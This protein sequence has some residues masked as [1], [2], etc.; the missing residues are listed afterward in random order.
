[1]AKDQKPANGSD[2]AHPR[3]LFSD[4]SSRTSE[5]AKGRHDIVESEHTSFFWPDVD[6]LLTQQLAGDLLDQFEGR[7]GPILEPLPRSAASG[8][9]IDSSDPIDPGE[10][11]SVTFGAITGPVQPVPE[12]KLSSEVASWSGPPAGRR[13]AH[14]VDPAGFDVAEN[15]DPGAGYDAFVPDLMSGPFAPSQAQ[16]LFTGPWSEPGRPL[17][18]LRPDPVVVNLET[19]PSPA[20]EEP[21]VTL[22]GLRGSRLFDPRPE[23]EPGVG[24]LNVGRLFDD[25][26]PDRS[27]SA[28]RANRSGRSEP[29]DIAVSSARLVSPFDGPESPERPLFERE[30]VLEVETTIPSLPGGSPLDFT[31]ELRLS[32]PAPN[33]GPPA[34]PV[35]LARSTV[36]DPSHGAPAG[37][38]FLDQPWTAP[39][40]TGPIAAS[41]LLRL[42]PARSGGLLY[43]EEDP[44][45]PSSGPHAVLRPMEP[46]QPNNGVPG[47]A[48]LLDLFDHQ[49]FVLMAGAA[50][51]LVGG[52]GW[53]ALS[54]LGAGGSDLVLDAS[55]AADVTLVSAGSVAGPTTVGPGSASPSAAV[56]SIAS[57]STTTASR[58]TTTR[59]GSTTSST[60]TG[61]TS[62]SVSTSGPSTSGPTTSATVASTTSTEVTTTTTAP[63]TT[64][65]RPTTTTTRPTTTTARPTTT[66][67]QPTTTTTEAP[68]TTTTAPTTPTS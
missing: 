61:S 33:P 20:S 51:L 2:V 32:S 56:S 1:M 53:F 44:A 25:A 13:G 64:T 29:D 14:D 45:Y 55:G 28:Q 27:T 62:S 10:F 34:A 50:A 18:N 39:E 38:L 65:T 24:R 19:E 40:A 66:T 23:V 16:N 59:K 9:P 37:S 48:A 46:L 43:L 36:V 60:V 6:E 54:R 3:D 4:R 17:D 31:S 63:T 12:L 15:S 57:G 42:E 41:S 21:M 52:L 47:F 67:T 11:P 58:A 8:D 26:D 22:D 35:S 30:P 5:A 49:R 7:P 68:T